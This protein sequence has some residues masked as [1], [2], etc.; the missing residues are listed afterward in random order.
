MATDLSAIGS[1]GLYRSDLYG[2]YNIVQTTQI[3]APKEILISALRHFFNQDSY[4]HFVYD[5]WGFP[6]TPDLTDVP[7][8][9]GLV[10]DTTTR[11]YIGEIYR[12]DQL[13]YPSV[14]VRN[15]GSTGIPIS[16]NRGK[17]EILYQASLVVDG[18]GNEKTY[19]EP[20]HFILYDAWEGTLQVDITT[21]SIRARDDLVE[22][23]SIYCKD[24]RFEELRRAGLVVKR[25]QA[26]APSEVD[27]RNGKLFKQ[28]ITLETRSEWRRQIPIGN[29]IE[30]IN[31]CVE[32]GNVETTPIETAPNIEIDATIEL[33]DAILAL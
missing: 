29:L 20:T 11:L 4:Y 31:L 16:M 1:G 19:V 22:L 17:E 23:I 25:V 30:R 8:D 10:D 3:S 15:G 18:Y 13:Y 26:G 33:A 2:I 14:V 9:A 21:K 5:E 32:L 28:S 7:Q 27:D 6:Q 12:Q 24:L